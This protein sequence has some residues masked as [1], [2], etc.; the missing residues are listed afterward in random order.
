MVGFRFLSTPA[1]GNRC[2]AGAF[3]FLSIAAFWVFFPGLFC[4]EWVV[5][6]AS[7]APGLLISISSATHGGSSILPRLL[8][9]FDFGESFRLNLD[10]LRD[11]RDGTLLLESDCGV[12][13][14]WLGAG[15]GGGVHFGPL[16]PL[17]DDKGELS[18]MSRFVT[19]S[20][21]YISP[22]H[23]HTHLYHPHLFLVTSRLPYLF[24]LLF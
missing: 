22:P 18:C 11:D 7:P 9:A 1:F 19:V 12:V 3:S 4:T 5:S 13:R 14:G 21:A 8:L 20:V 17:L 23:T 24:L 6:S 10:L 15:K 2:W 16:R